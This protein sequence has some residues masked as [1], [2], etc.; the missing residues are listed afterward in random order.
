M[1]SFLNKSQDILEYTNSYV[2]PH[3]IPFF[4]VFD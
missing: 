1:T 4:Q 2:L 3:S